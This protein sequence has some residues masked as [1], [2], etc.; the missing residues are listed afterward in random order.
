MS[1]VAQLSISA[2]TQSNVKAHATPGVIYNASSSIFASSEVEIKQIE[3]KYKSLKSIF[4]LQNKKIINFYPKVDVE[5]Y[6][7][8]S[9]TGSIFGT[10]FDSKEF[11]TATSSLSLDKNDAGSPLLTTLASFRGKGSSLVIGGDK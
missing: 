10:T 9:T 6:N 4:K 5:Q 7:L 2:K 11:L 1:S 8:T 3:R